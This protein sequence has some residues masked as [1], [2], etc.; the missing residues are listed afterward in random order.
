MLRYFLLFFALP[1]VLS[2]Q[3]DSMDYRRLQ[4]GVV[5]GL[6]FN[7]VD[8]SPNQDVTTREGMTYGLALRY[9]DKQL[10]GFQAEVV[11]AEAGWLEDYGADGESTY[12]R[13][14]EYAELQI[15][16]QFSIGR[17]VIQPLI[18]AGPYL[19]VPIGSEEVLPPD[20][21]PEA[22]PP[23]SY[24]GREIS[25]RLNY[26]LRAGVGLN[27]ELG[28]LT[29]Q[30]EGRYLQGFSNLIR[31][32]DSQVSTSIRRAYAGRVGLFYAIR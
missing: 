29:V 18:Q 15:L 31:P 21:Q 17:G 24:R 19:S 6:S 14:Y 20:L 4:V 9:F 30:L 5:G 2:G 23:N 1:Q 10:V 3:A 7:E 27:V 16:T 26:G 22:E 12:E 25:D 11:Y 32:G 28:P 13:R 8:F